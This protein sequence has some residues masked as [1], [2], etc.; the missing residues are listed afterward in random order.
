LHDSA[1]SADNA[2]AQ[3]MLADAYLQGEH[4]KENSEKGMYWLNMAAKQGLKQA[5]VMLAEL[6]N[7]E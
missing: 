2:L 4:V 1:R 5:Q 7:N 3:F 6:N